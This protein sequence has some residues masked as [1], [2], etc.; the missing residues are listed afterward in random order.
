L[1]SGAQSTRDDHCIATAEIGSNDGQVHWIAEMWA[2]DVSCSWC[3]RVCLLTLNRI[4][5]LATGQVT[6]VNIRD[7]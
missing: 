2:G 7:L 5:R 4:S 6:I 1:R 3:G